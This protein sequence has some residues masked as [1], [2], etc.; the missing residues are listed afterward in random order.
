MKRFTPFLTVAL[1]AFLAVSC[2]DSNSLDDI[3]LDSTEPDGTIEVDEEG[4]APAPS[5][6]PAPATQDTAPAPAN[7]SEYDESVPNPLESDAGLS[8]GVAVPLEEAQSMQGAIHPFMTQ[9]LQ[10]FIQKEG[11]IPTSFA[12]FASARMDSVPFPPDG[13][14]YVI[15]PVARQVKVVKK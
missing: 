8:S 12:E 10:M 2:S 5:R 15:D 7:D 14:K 1:T 4:D 11:R 3:D 9:Q 6:A 13:M